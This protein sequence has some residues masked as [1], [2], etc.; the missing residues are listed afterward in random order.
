MIEKEGIIAGNNYKKGPQMFISRKEELSEL[1]RRYRSQQFEC[2][3]IYGRRR[4]GK[5]SLINE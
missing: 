1:E 3:I 2:I 5:T 4:I